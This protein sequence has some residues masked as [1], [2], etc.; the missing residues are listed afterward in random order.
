MNPNRFCC[1]VQLKKNVRPT[2]DR[3]E[4]SDRHVVLYVSEVSDFIFVIVFVFLSKFVASLRFVTRG[5][6]RIW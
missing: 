1:F 3:F 5:K 6:I 2:V 4:I